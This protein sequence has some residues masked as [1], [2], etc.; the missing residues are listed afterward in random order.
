MKRLRMLCMVGLFAVLFTITACQS[1]GDETHT[2]IPAKD[3]FPMVKEEAAD[4]IMPA[5]GFGPAYRANV[6]QQ[7]VENPWPSIETTDVV[8]GS[9]SNEA[10]ITYRDNIETKAGETRN[11][12]IMVII[13]N[14]NNI[15]RLLLT[16]NKNVR[17]LNLYSN[18]VPAGISLIDAMRWGGPN[19]MASVLVIEIS[20]DV[21]TG[22]Y[23]FEIGLEIN[24]KDYGTVPCTIKVLE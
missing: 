8:L 6:H 16:P 3:L 11:N 2:S 7:G 12:I 17:S 23:T 22:Q 13:P 14:E 5:P 18:N 20:Q 24:G 19:S 15:I 10:H 1:G 9:G 21:P 4:D